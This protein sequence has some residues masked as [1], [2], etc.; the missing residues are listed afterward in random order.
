MSGAGERA[1]APAVASI[2]L[3]ALGLDRG[4][5]LLLRA[6]LHR[7]AAGERLCVRGSAPDLGV[8]LR[9]WARAEGHGFREL[10]P[11]A[12]SRSSSGASPAVAELER[13]TASGARWR[14]AERAC[15]ADAREAVAE[16][17]ARWGLAARGAAVEAG[18]PEIPFALCRRDEIWTDDA[19]ALYREA[20]AAQWDPE[21]AIP[22]HAP[23]E[24]GELVEDALVQILTYLVENE[25]AALLV[26]ARFCAQVHPQY[27]EIQQLLAIQAA[28]EARHIEVFT[29]RALLAHRELGLSTGGGQASLK[30]LLEE[31][32]FALASF[33]LSVL[34]EGSFLH[35]LGFLHQHAPD[36]CTRAI[37][38]LVAQDEARHVAFGM[39]HLRRHIALEPGLLARL[40][41]AV[42]RRAD[43]L[44]HTAGLNAEVFD[45]LVLLAAGELAPRAIERGHAAVAALVAQM[46]SGRRTRLRRLGFEERDAAE[47]SGLHT[48]NFM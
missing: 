14:G 35:L 2:E 22:W 10:A 28:D 40:R 45:A 38:R 18:S 6:A 7:L 27:R 13:G 36:E 19:A 11:D 41:L 8:H 17:P 46:D 42:E 32:D 31:P 23:R 29:R 5:G 33:L 39:A 20:A 30:T 48:R 43:A 1:P 9:A 25:T 12:T 24:H 44:R 47:L 21:S 34:G 37:M 16:A 3:E 4:A 26:P 15:G